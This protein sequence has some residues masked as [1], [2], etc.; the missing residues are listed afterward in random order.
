MVPLI[1]GMR[2]RLL[3]HMYKRACAGGEKEVQRMFRTFD[4]AASLLMLKVCV[5]IHDFVYV[6]CG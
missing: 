5:F 2:H 3:V 1:T 6:Y 4:D